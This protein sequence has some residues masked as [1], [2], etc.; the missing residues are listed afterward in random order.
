MVDRCNEPRSMSTL[1][2][3]EMGSQ[4]YSTINLQ[5]LLENGLESSTLANQLL[6]SDLKSFCTSTT[7]SLANIL[8]IEII[9][10]KIAS[11]TIS[12]ANRL[13]ID[14][15]DVDIASTTQINTL[16]VDLE[17]RLASTTQ[18]GGLNVDPIDEEF[19]SGTIIRTLNSNIDSFATSLTNSPNVLA[20]LGESEFRSTT[21]PSILL[22]SDLNTN[23]SSITSINRNIQYLF[24]SEQLESTT[25]PGIAL[26]ANLEGELRSST[27]PLRGLIASLDTKLSSTTD[28]YL[29]LAC[30]GLTALESLTRA[31]SDPLEAAPIE[32]LLS[33]TTKA[34][35]NDARPTDL[36][37]LS[38]EYDWSESYDL[39]VELE[40][41]VILTQEVI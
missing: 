38:A 11:I 5:S 10:E 23:L 16:S 22:I 13:D 30:E 31:L 6:Y 39:W 19:I 36:C 3:S 40:E 34:S 17:D 1:L 35:K 28:Q 8:E 21:N 24:I 20:V 32:E 14:P 12:L 33:S 18:A 9:D 25:I 37:L 26:L 4:T 41:I 2:V 29:P 27:E 15:L 7:E